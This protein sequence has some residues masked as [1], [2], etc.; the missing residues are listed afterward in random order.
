[1][2]TALEI[3]VIDHQAVDVVVNRTEARTLTQLYK[4]ISTVPR[5]TSQA[6]Q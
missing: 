6:R 5:T 3:A 4:I 1:M 2:Q